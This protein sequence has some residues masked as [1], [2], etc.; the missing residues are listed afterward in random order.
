MS[1]AGLDTSCPMLK[2]PIC[3]FRMTVAGVILC[4][5]SLDVAESKPDGEFIV[6]QSI[7]TLS[8]SSGLDSRSASYI[9]NMSDITMIWR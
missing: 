8:R 1:L 5:A 7:L 4:P 9:Q 3:K 6:E 2:A